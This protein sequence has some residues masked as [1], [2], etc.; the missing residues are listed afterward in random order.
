MENTPVREKLP[1]QNVRRELTLTAREALPAHLARQG[2]TLLEL[3]DQLNALHAFKENTLPAQE[4]HTA[5][6]VR[7]EPPLPAKEPLPAQ[8]AHHVR[9]AHTLLPAVLRLMALKCLMSPLSAHLAPK[10]QLHRRN[11]PRNRNVSPPTWES[12][13]TAQAE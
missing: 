9:Q 3:R 4:T 12:S 13:A 5:K 10:A 7:R 11:Q 2:Q 6:Y 1:A 8:L